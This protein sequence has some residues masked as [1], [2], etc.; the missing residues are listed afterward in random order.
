MRRQLDRPLRRLGGLGAPALRREKLAQQVARGPIVINHQNSLHKISFSLLRETDRMYRIV[1][2]SNN[3][4]DPEQSC[5]SCLLSSSRNGVSDEPSA[6]S[7]LRAG[8][9]KRKRVPCPGSLSTSIW[10][11]CSCITWMTT[12]RPSPSPLPLSFVEYSGSKICA[13]VRRD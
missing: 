1:Q 8:K 13:G 2:D 5:K 4:Q 12:S 11:P 6:S 7:P 3:S 9:L 10:P